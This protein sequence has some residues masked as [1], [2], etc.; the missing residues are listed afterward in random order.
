MLDYILIV[1]SESVTLFSGSI[2]RFFFV[3]HKSKLQGMILNCNE[4]KMKSVVDFISISSGDDECRKQFKSIYIYGKSSNCIRCFHGNN[5]WFC[6]EIEKLI[7]LCLWKT[8]MHKGEKQL[9][10]SK[11]S[12]WNFFESVFREK[13][14]PSVCFKS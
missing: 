14:N 12:L 5:F 6:A 11:D 1:F 10:F 8:T 9:R 4:M 13:K 3:R 7:H 2:H